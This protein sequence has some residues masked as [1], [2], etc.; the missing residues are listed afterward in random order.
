MNAKCIEALKTIRDGVDS[1]LNELEKGEST[2]NCTNETR[3]KVP[4]KQDRGA[5]KETVKDTV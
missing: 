5:V 4:A 1:L 3:G 2:C